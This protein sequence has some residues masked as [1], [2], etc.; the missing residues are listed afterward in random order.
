MCM[1][2]FVHVMSL[3]VRMRLQ[4]PPNGA[5]ECVVDGVATTTVITI[6]APVLM[7]DETSGLVMTLTYDAALVSMVRGGGPSLFNTTAAVETVTEEHVVVCDDGSGVSLY[8]DDVSSTECPSPMSPVSSLLPRDLCL[9]GD[10]GSGPPGV[11][12]FIAASCA[13]GYQVL[14][15]CGGNPPYFCVKTK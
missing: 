8:I 15:V 3:C 13:T 6:T 9:A 5:L 2:A 4:V 7:A 12:P 10:N 14:P 1:Y 11:G